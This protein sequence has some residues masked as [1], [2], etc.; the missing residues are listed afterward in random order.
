MRVIGAFTAAAPDAARRMT[1]ADLTRRLDDFA[2]RRLSRGE[3]QQ[4][5]DAVLAADAFGA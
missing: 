4:W 5:F 2:D 3:L 1:L